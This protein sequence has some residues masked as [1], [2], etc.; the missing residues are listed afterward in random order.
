MNQLACDVNLTEQAEL[1]RLEGGISWSDERVNATLVPGF[2][3]EIA[4]F[5][6]ADA[7]FEITASTSDAVTA[8]VLLMHE[9]DAEAMPLLSALGHLMPNA[10]NEPT[11]FSSTV[12]AAKKRERGPTLTEQR[13][14]V[15]ADAEK[16]EERKHSNAVGF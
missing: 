2:T 15:A 7:E 8:P 11:V 4:D 1:L 9:V 12:A 10:D 5:L 14:R 6:A 3:D 16:A 13:F